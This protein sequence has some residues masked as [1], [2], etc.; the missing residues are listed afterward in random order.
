M[1]LAGV[2]WACLALHH[3]EARLPFR[4][5]LLQA[6]ERI[7]LPA[8]IALAAGRLHVA[9]TLAV[10]EGVVV[11]SWAPNWRKPAPGMLAFAREILTAAGAAGSWAYVG[12]EEDDRRAAEAAGMAFIPAE[13][14]HSAG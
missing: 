7:R 9:I 1:R 11:A 2:R 3:P 14:I 13:R 5:A 4:K 6:A 10:P 12:D 8:E